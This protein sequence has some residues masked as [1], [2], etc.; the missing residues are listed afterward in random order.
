MISHG[1][2]NYENPFSSFGRDAF[3]LA[4]KHRE[5]ELGDDLMV[6]AAKRG[7]AIRDVFSKEKHD[8][9]LTIESGLEDGDTFWNWS[10]GLKALSDYP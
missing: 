3:L 7:L 1:D 2:E 5:S 9:Y 10:A 8:Q 4:I 6:L